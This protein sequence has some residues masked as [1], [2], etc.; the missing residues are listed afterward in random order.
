MAE[1]S[2]NLSMDWQSRIVLV[3]MAR[4]IALIAMT[5]FHFGWDLEM[6]GFADRG[7]ASQPAMI[8][9]ARCIA[10]SFL[11]LV[12]FSLVLAHQGKFNPKGFLWRLA[13]IAGAALLITIATRIATP[14][15]F[16]FFGIL[17][18]IAVASV[19]GLIFIY[20]PWWVSLLS[21]VGVLA[22][23]FNLRTPMLDAPWWWWSGLSDYLPRSSDYVPVF[24]FFAAVLTGLA[25]ARVLIMNGWTKRLAAI[26]PGNRL[27]GLLGFIGR[28]SLIYYLVHQPVMIAI[29][30]GFHLVTR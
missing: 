22:A 1:S 3:D 16:I 24:P 13:K 19:L 26:N 8:W 23:Y 29:L 18:H 14:D 17:H 5:M 7:F 25:S 12:G 6:F 20:L 2:T 9:F 4:G 27:A 28:H 11:F 21:A 15:I 10:S 30:Y